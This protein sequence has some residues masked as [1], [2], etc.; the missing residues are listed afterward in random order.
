MIKKMSK[1]FFIFCLTL[2][3]IL[4]FTFSQFLDSS[5]AYKKLFPKVDPRGLIPATPSLPQLLEPLKVVRPLLY[6][7]N[8]SFYVRNRSDYDIN[9]V[10]LVQYQENG[11]IIRTLVTSDHTTAVPCEQRRTSGWGGYNTEIKVSVPK[12]HDPSDEPDVAPYCNFEYIQQ[13]VC[14][15]DNI[16]YYDTSFLTF[17]FAP[18]VNHLPGYI[19]IR[20]TMFI[21]NPTFEYSY[22][23]RFEQV[24]RGPDGRL[25]LYR[26]GS[27]FFQYSDSALFQGPVLLDTLIDEGYAVYDNVDFG[28]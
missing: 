4:S 27:W 10:W 28:D 17:P 6:V 24:Y 16:V 13:R 12:L 11:A 22:N 1:K 18:G 14:F 25:Y 2:F 20:E 26:P 8:V 21:W 23:S 9:E 19:L 15:G 5:A 3:F 7:L